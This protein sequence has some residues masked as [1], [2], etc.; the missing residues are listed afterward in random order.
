MNFT[1]DA[2]YLARMRA[3]DKATL[4]HFYE[5][6]ALP[7]RNR[8]AHSVAW[9]DVDDLVQDFFA[10]ILPRIDAGQP[11]D[12]AK[13]P[14]YV[15][16]TCQNL[17]YHH[18]RRGKKNSLLVNEF[19][20]FVDV[21]ESVEAQMIRGLNNQPVQQILQELP[22]RYRE[23]IHRRFVLE[24]DTP[25]AA[26]A[27]GTTSQNFRLILCHTLRRF[28]ELWE[29]YFGDPPTAGSFVIP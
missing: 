17:I 2:E 9:Q 27:M 19:S 7:I 4:K 1:F 21:C 18:W 29:R 14:G 10:A 15:I 13:L 20:E 12:P 26:K 16:H 6:F 24:E 11:R 5:C 25:T 3:R 8:V 28:R 23:A 22:V